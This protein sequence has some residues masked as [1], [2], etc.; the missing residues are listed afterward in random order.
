MELWKWH[1]AMMMGK[2]GD[3]RRNGSIVMKGFDGSEVARYNFEQRLAQQ[4]FDG[5]AQGR[6]ERGP[7][8]GGLDRHRSPEP[9]GVGHGRRKPGARRAPPA[10]RATSF[11]PSSR[12]SCRAATSI[13]TGVVHRDGVM[14]LAT[15]KDEIIPQRDPRVRE[16]ESYLTVL[17]LS[18]V[19]TRLGRLPEVNPG[20]DR[21]HV[22]LRPG[23]PPGPVPPDQ[24]G[25]HQPGG[26]HLPLVPARVRGRDGR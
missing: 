20:V 11:G 24:P 4:G 2:L 13:S 1:E 19:V 5:H 23:V 26:R 18:R 6:L 16:N 7:D 8:G 15:A 22:R 12:S 17:L 25:G 14:R 10:T 9:G 3:A 21:E